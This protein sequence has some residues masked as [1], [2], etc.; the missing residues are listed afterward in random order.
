MPKKTD[1]MKSD[2]QSRLPFPGC[3]WSKQIHTNR[4]EKQVCLVLGEWGMSVF[5]RAESPLGKKRKF[6]R[7]TEVLEYIHISVDIFNATELNAKSG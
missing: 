6:L 5:K 3:S 2:R 4:E 1:T 7:R